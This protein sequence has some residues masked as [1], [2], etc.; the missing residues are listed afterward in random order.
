[1]SLAAPDAVAS[2]QPHMFG[3]PPIGRLFLSLAIGCLIL[4]ACGPA[5][6]LPLYEATQ[7]TRLANLTGRLE[8]RG[9]CLVIV[10]GTGAVRTV[11]WPTPGTEW[12]VLTQSV[13]LNG[14]AAPVGATVTLTGGEI[15]KPREVTDDLAAWPR[16]PLPD[17][18]NNPIWLA[19]QLHL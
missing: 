19:S 4:P 2:E 9:P 18:L 14:V 1:M 5:P 17:C 8:A 15:L 13:E 11:A 16:P 12:N 10:D 3:P 7:E 6:S